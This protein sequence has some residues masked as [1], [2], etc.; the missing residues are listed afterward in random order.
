M[1]NP[2]YDPEEDVSRHGAADEKDCDNMRKKYGWKLKR[3]E[4][5]DRKILEVDCVFEGDT[6]FPRPYHETETED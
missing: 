5:T 6:E 4:R 3:T 2:R 1:V